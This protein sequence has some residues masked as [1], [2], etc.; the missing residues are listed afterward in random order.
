M[1]YAIADASFLYI[2][3]CF[4]QAKVLTSSAQA[5]VDINELEAIDITQGWPTGS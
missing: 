1:L 2:Q 4:S 5:A 3:G